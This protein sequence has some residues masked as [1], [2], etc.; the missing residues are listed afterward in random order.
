[1]KKINTLCLIDDDSVY[2]FLTTKVIC[3]TK[4]VDHVK[5][6]P[7]GLE[8]LEFLKDVRDTSE[9]LP[10]VIMLDLTMPVM[11]GWDFLEEYVAL[12]PTFGKKVMLY[13]VTSS[14]APS[15]MIR[16]RS[17][18]TVSD[19][20]TKPVTKDKFLTVLKNIA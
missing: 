13:I 18:S 7:N 1:M 8:A 5:A 2:Q 16:A 6:F 4:L 20:I 10:D 11:D 19:F 12:Q 14:I 15:D 9:K 17:I 3:E